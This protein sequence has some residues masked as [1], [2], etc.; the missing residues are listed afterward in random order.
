MNLP[1]EFDP[2]LIAEAR[3]IIFTANSEEITGKRIL[4]ANDT[5][6]KDYFYA[7]NAEQT[8]ALSVD[9][10]ED[11]GDDDLARFVEQYFPAP[12]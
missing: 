12:R 1:P 10:S 8:A 4:F 6:G 2:S 11:L 7:L 3:D 5:N 9:V